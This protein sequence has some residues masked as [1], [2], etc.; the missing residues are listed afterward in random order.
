MG[1]YNTPEISY[2]NFKFVAAS[3]YPTPKVSLSINVER[4]SSEAYL[5]TTTTI[6]LDGVVMSGT[7]KYT[8]MAN[9][10]KALQLHSGLFKQPNPSYLTIKSE[11][12]GGTDHYVIFSGLATVESINFNSDNDP[13]LQTIP[14]DITFKSIE[15]RPPPQSGISEVSKLKFFVQNVQ[16]SYDITPNLNQLYP[17]GTGSISFSGAIYPTY[18]ISRSMR[19]QGKNTNSGALIE[20]AHWI[21]WR[22]KEKTS[23]TG[24]IPTAIYSLYNLERDIDVDPVEGSVSVRDRFLAKPSGPP[25]I[26]QCSVSTTIDDTYQRTVNIKGSI[27]GLEQFDWVNVT[28]NIFP[29]SGSSFIRPSY[30]GII[31]P[32]NKYTNALSGYLQITGIMFNRAKIFDE[33]TKK[34]VPYDANNAQVFS[35]YR[36][37]DLNPFPISITEGLNPAKGTI[38][39]DY[40]FNTRPLALISG[41]LTERFTIDDSGPAIKYTPI[42]VIGRRLGPLLYSQ[43][44]MSAGSRTVSYEA[45]FNSP[46]GLKKM[47][48]DTN[49][50]K[51]IDNLLDMFK[52]ESPYTGLLTSNDRSVN[53][54][55]NRILHTKV[56]QYT[57]CADS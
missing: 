10:E 7:G 43:G 35:N 19:A 23:F 18:T 30:S 36:T 34:A 55:E 31:N 49:I 56:W 28:G 50:M 33:Y 17:S 9:F 1:I 53:F 26:E 6:S 13:S 44:M 25:Y 21:N 32:Q 24:I 29:T 39:Y 27:E 47:R 20:A 41:A 54:S 48:E 22:A 45:T 3:G 37:T 16:D 8:P 38:D 15:T 52:P 14:Y 4:T 11:Q 5:G 57:K 2:G 12:N 40:S 46:T 42:D 51:A